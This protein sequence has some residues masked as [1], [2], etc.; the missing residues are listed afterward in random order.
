MLKRRNDV[1]RDLN[2]R[3]VGFGTAKVTEN[4]G[5]AVTF[6]GVKGQLV[7]GASCHRRSDK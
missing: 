2:R 4:R 7:D 1:E 6:S 3:L 5:E